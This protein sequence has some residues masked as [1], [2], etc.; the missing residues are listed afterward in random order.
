MIIASLPLDIKSKH[1]FN[2]DWLYSFQ[3]KQKFAGASNVI[4]KIAKS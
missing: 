2:E 1:Y 4:G 3:L